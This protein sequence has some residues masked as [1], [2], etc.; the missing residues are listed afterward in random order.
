MTAIATIGLALGPLSES[1]RWRNPRGVETAERDLGLWRFN[2]GAGI[3]GKEQGRGGWL[4][5]PADGTDRVGWSTRDDV[6]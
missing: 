1:P 5:V 4:I 3:G 6:S 2:R